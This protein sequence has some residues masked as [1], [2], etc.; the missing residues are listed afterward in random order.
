MVNS[1]APEPAYAVAVL[2]AVPT[3]ANAVKPVKPVV[4][5]T[6]GGATFKFKVA[7]LDTGATLPLK[8]GYVG[9]QGVKA[10][11]RP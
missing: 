7:M 1:I 3:P 11:S 10:S 6:P 4:I 5:V 8:A 2:R 9:G